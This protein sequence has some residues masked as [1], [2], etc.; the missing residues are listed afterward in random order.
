M[1]LKEAK[2]RKKSSFTNTLVHGEQVAHFVY[3][4]EHPRPFIFPKFHLQSFTPS[5]ENPPHLARLGC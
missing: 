1:V 2:N 5:F 4:L 3:Y